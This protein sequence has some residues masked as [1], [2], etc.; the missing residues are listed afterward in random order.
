MITSDPIAAESGYKQGTHRGDIEAYNINN[1]SD[2]MKSFKDEID[3]LKNEN[4]SLRHDVTTLKKDVQ[5]LMLIGIDEEER[6]A[7][8]LS[9]SESKG[10]YYSNTSSA[11]ANV[12]AALVMPGTKEKTKSK[13]KKRKSNKAKYGGAGGNV[14]NIGGTRSSIVKMLAVGSV[15]IAL[16]LGQRT[17]G[18][19]AIRKKLLK[20]V[21]SSRVYQEGKAPPTEMLT[22]KVQ[23]NI[24]PRNLQAATQSTSPYVPPSNSQ[25]S[26]KSS[27]PSST[28]SSLANQPSIYAPGNLN[29]ASTKRRSA[30]SRTF[31]CDT[32]PMT[33]GCPNLN[34]TDYRGFINTT[35]YGPCLSWDEDFLSDYPDAG[36]EDNYCRNPSNDHDAWCWIEVED[37]A[38][39]Y[40]LP[41][42]C[43]VP[44]CREAL[45]TATPTA[46]S[47]PTVSTKPTTSLSPSSNPSSSSSPTQTCAIADKETCGCAV[48]GQADYRGKISTTQGGVECHRWDS[49]SVK[50][51]FDGL[52]DFLEQFPYAGLEDNNFCRNPAN[53]TDGPLCFGTAPNSID[54]D[55]TDYCDVPFCN[56][57]SCMPPC[58]EPN[59]Q[60]CGC[61]NALQ[62]DG[63]CEGG[64]Y[65]CKCTY[66]KEACRKS[67][68]NNRTDFCDDAEEACCQVSVDP[69]CKCGMYEQICAESPFACDTAADNCCNEQFFFTS[70]TCRCDFYT[71]T[72]NALGYESSES[73]KEVVCEEVLAVQFSTPKLETLLL[74]ALFEQTGGEYWLN[75]TGWADDDVPQCQWI[76]LTCNDDGLI[77]EINLGTNNLTGG[78]S[79]LFFDF[80]ELIS[81]DISGNNL[82]GQVPYTNLRK[83]AH[84]NFSNNS[85]N[86]AAS[87]LFT[88][89]TS[90]VNFSFNNFTSVSFKRFNAAYDTLKVVDLS[91]NQIDQ[92]V[93]DIFVNIPPKLECISLSSNALNGALPD[94]ILLERM[95]DFRIARNNI[96]GTVP[97]FQTPRLRYLDL[98]HQAENGGLTGSIPKSL[99]QIS[100]LQT[101]ILASNALSLSIPSDFGDM[102][103]LQLLD[104]SSNALSQTIPSDLGGLKGII[105]V[106][107]LAHNELRGFIP[108]ELSALEDT[109]VRLEGNSKLSN[110]SPLLL[111]F[112]PNFDVMNDPIM[113]PLDRSALNEFYHAA[114]GQEWT[115]SDLW[116]DNYEGHCSWYGV[117]C[118]GSNKTVELKLASNGLSGTLTEKISNLS[119]IEVLDLSD[120]RIKGSIPTEVGLLSNL[121]YLRLAYNDFRGNETNFGELQHLKLIQLHGNRLSGTLPSLNLEFID[122]SSYIS[123]CGNPSDFEDSLVC[124]ECT[125][126]CNMQDDCYPQEESDIQKLGFANFMYFTGAFM[127]GIFV[128]CCALAFASFIYDVRHTINLRS[129][130]KDL[131]RKYALGTVGDDSVY[132]FLLGTTFIGWLIVLIT[133]CSQMWMLFVFVQGSE[134]DL[135]DDQSDLAYTLKCPRDDDE[136]R[137]SSDLDWRGWTV[138]AILMSAN[139]LKDA[140]NGAKLIVLSAK[141][142]HSSNTK[143]RLFFGGT[144]LTSVTSFT[145]YVSTIYNAAIATSNTEIIMNS[146]VIL[147]ITDV[148]ELVYDILTVI[149]P[150]WV[151]TMSPE[152]KEESEDKPVSH[153]QDGEEDLQEQQTKQAGV[154]NLK[155]YDNLVRDF[156]ILHKN[157]DIMQEQNA[158]LKKDV[159]KLHEYMGLMQEQS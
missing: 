20:I 86:G 135:S 69:S 84:I 144:L 39:T 96:N 47:K 95:T 112:M 65:S 108:P 153:E 80:P 59:D 55:T 75:R 70:D 42:L 5:A 124:I 126:C 60:T 137:D 159:E 38:S 106:L 3:L 138:Y 113:C 57:C 8:T 92:D 46:F 79:T 19:G 78:L 118:N 28:A 82:S 155:K 24:L 107:D 147:F 149:N 2:G 151:E 81:I 122:P 94:P 48:V 129:F 146:V 89:V 25:V 44:M 34:Q 71:Y 27:D 127:G 145:F 30:S 73:K 76:G 140:I 131:D 43:E 15:F 110:P 53:S 23:K 6:A 18:G 67:L 102:R 74:R 90:Y 134:I 13:S 142:R 119:M 97:T 87:M 83:L 26:S 1:N 12:A 62:A 33:C 35:P 72:S 132:S 16:A 31:L 9:I 14:M 54:G 136:C 150:D 98:S 77:T 10:E 50:E 32:D 109:L 139:L 141:R 114:K 56:P 93:S 37:A 64:D 105:E 116:L 152:V 128:A 11:E 143:A 158:Q 154:Y 99:S 100:S 58:G 4:K 51:G 85:L 117:E 104:L 52:I 22:P 125:M 36:L 21:E 29:R 101:I 45:P 111:C 68:E 130:S 120:N 156:E 17:I 133:I 49:E 157:M 88:P 91:N 40:Y 115:N 121:I 66:L 7:N 123:D 63:C 103:S 61:P 148:D 41:A